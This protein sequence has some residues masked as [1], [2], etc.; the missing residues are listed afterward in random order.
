MSLYWGGKNKIKTLCKNV[1][2]SVSVCLSSSTVSTRRLSL[3]RRI[4]RFGFVSEGIIQITK[5]VINDI[6]AHSF[7][8]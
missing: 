3:S 5:L 1:S 2:V 8:M 7:N 4:K 6:A